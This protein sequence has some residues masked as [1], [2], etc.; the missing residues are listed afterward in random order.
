MD[1]VVVL[2]SLLSHNMIH[3]SPFLLLGVNIIMPKALEELCVKL[4]Y[5]SF[6]TLYIP[7]RSYSGPEIL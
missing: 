4:F 5:K 6:S 1:K 2:C 3:L 7:G